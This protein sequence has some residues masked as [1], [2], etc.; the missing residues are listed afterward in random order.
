MFRAGMPSPRAAPFRLPRVVQVRAFVGVLIG[1]ATIAVWVSSW[2]D[3]LMSVLGALDMMFA[4][5]AVGACPQLGQ[6]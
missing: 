1:L 3:P 6:W 2:A 5:T 4:S